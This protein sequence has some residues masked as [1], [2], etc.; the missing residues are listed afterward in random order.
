MHKLPAING[1]SSCKNVSLP[2]CSK[3]IILKADKEKR[4]NFLRALTIF[5][6]FL[7]TKHKCVGVFRVPKLI[8]S[9]MIRWLLSQ[10]GMSHINPPDVPHTP[11][12][13]L[14]CTILKRS[15]SSFSASY[16]LINLMKHDR[17][18][19]ELHLHGMR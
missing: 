10:G 11:S 15:G 9:M 13:F 7:A 3:K 17:L 8:S 14:S 16:I 12:L 18:E 1:V 6:G 2:G 5:C 19:T 4:V